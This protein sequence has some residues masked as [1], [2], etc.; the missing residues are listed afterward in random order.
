MHNIIIQFIIDTFGI[1]S[2]F[3]LEK[4]NKNFPLE[5]TNENLKFDIELSHKHNYY[6]KYRTVL[7]DIRIIHSAF[8]L[9]LLL[10][11]SFDS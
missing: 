1:I 5:H 8:E 2:F 4:V 6:D 9:I 3:R 7:T 11:S 10:W